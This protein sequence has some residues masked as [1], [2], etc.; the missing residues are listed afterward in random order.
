[1]YSMKVRSGNISYSPYLSSYYNKLKKEE[2]GKFIQLDEG[3]GLKFNE[4]EIWYT[5]HNRQISYFSKPNNAFLEFRNNLSVEELT[6]EEFMKIFSHKLRI[7]KVHK[8]NNSI[9]LVLYSN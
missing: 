7:H 8:I 3:Y 4:H 2:E 5:K 9:F 6:N 1:M